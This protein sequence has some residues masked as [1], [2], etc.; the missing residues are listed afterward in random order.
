MVLFAVIAGAAA[1][2]SASLAAPIFPEPKP[3]PYDGSFNDLTVANIA[4]KYH[5]FTFNMRNKKENA[6]VE[7]YVKIDQKARVPAYN[8]DTGVAYIAVDDTSIFKNQTNFRRSELSQFIKT[9]P[10][11]KTFIRA[12]FMKEDEFLNPRQWQMFQAE[13]L[14][15][16]IGVDASVEPPQVI[17]YNNHEW[18]PKWQTDFKTKTWY[19]FGVAIS[20][21]PKG[22]GSV[23]ELYTSVG[24]NELKLMTTHSVVTKFA[25][26][27]DIHFGI[28]TLSNYENAAPK[29][30]EG[31]DVICFNGISAKD[32]VTTAAAGVV[33]GFK[34]T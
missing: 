21:D 6:K 17:Y 16:Q 29:M 8:N 7:K 26:S 15:F 9:N 14:I 32:H 30:N 19:N 34:S 2:V 13:S 22:D 4:D 33:V 24:D 27:E 3:L 10:K 5:T 1:L 20:K 28:L 31:Q 12:S 25:E 18:V 11:G 23:V